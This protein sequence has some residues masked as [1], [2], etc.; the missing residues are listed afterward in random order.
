MMSVGPIGFNQMSLSGSHMGSSKTAGQ[1]N[2]QMRATTE[3]DDDRRN[4]Q[5]SDLHEN[6]DEHSRPNGEEQK[7]PQF[8][9]D[10]LFTVKDLQEE[11]AGNKKRRGREKLK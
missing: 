4:L 10:P 3:A 6:H 8:Y 11:G 2:G 9:Q 5:M 7:L 1:A